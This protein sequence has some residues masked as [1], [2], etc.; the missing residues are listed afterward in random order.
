MSEGKKLKIDW[1]AL[2]SE[3]IDVVREFAGD[4][5]EG[6][7]EDIEDFWGEGATLLQAA[8]MMDDDDA[9]RRV[10]NALK[11]VAER[12]RLRIVNEKWEALEKGIDIAKRVASA[13]LSSVISFI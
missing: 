13:A 1:G 10:K 5:V 11:V 6:A 3:A 2:G 12:N 9:V 4:V 8:L 7:A